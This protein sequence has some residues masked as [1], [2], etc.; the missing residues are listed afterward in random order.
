MK[1]TYQEFTKTEFEEA[2]AS[3]G[4]GD[5]KLFDPAN[6]A[7]KEYVYRLELSNGLA[8]DIYSSVDKRSNTARRV[9]GDAI[10]VVPLYLLKRKP[11]SLGKRKRTY[12]TTSWKQNLENNINETLEYL[13]ENNPLGNCGHVLTKR[14]NRKTKGHFWGCLEYPNCRNTKEYN[15][16]IAS[17]VE[18]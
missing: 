6:M 18:V 1:E 12:R 4:L 10:R 11:M 5:F 7:T 16:S 3:Y 17:E 15:E 8:I 13:S 9:G 2:L 14:E